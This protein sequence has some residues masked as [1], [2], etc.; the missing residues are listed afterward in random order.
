MNKLLAYAIFD[1][2]SQLYGPLLVFRTAGEAMRYF[3]TTLRS[4]PLIYF[5]RND[6]ALYLISEYDQASGEITPLNRHVINGSDPA[7]AHMIG[8]D[9]QSADQDD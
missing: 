1:S 6:Y 3:S 4:D 2:V 9:Q 8:D 7:F 5:N